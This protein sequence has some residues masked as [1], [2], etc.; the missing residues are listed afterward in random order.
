MSYVVQAP[1]G[2][3]FDRFTKC[4]NG[5]LVPHFVREVAKAKKFTHKTEAYARNFD[6]NAARPDHA[7][8]CNVALFEPRS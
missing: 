1:N 8:L 7:G 2:W 3:F 5:T 6:C 4:A